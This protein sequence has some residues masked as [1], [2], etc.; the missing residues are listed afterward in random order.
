MTENIQPWSTRPTE[1]S[2]LVISRIAAARG[3]KSTGY[4]RFDAGRTAGS[5]TACR[6]SKL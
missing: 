1:S 4:E 6:G 2:A 3:D 5:K